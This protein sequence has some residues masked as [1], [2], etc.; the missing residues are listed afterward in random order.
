M[1]LSA[2]NV[3][4]FLS[5][6]FLTAKVEADF[7][8]E[9]DENR[10]LYSCSD[11]EA[12]MVQT[13]HQSNRTKTFW[14]RRCSSFVHRELFILKLCPM[15][16]AFK[17]VLHLHLLRRN[18]TTLFI[19]NYSVCVFWLE[20]TLE[21][22][23]ILFVWELPVCSDL[24]C[25]VWR[26]SKADVPHQG[27]GLFWDLPEIQRGTA[28]LEHQIRNLH[29]MLCCGCNMSDWPNTC[30]KSHRSHLSWA[31]VRKVYVHICRLLLDLQFLIRVCV[32]LEVDTIP[33]A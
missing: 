25:R 9:A 32:Y 21:K 7:L 28:S 15:M 11:V 1:Y 30:P 26:A 23:I 14:N 5:A 22:D 27:L 24:F 29:R 3:C 8:P 12:W 33:I 2:A 13:K 31:V 18:I 4:P 17:H 20:I 6:S 10:L 19:P 16:E